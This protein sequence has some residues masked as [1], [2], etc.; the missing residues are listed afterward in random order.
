MT[1]Q[2]FDKWQL[3]RDTFNLMFQIWHLVRVAQ[4]DVYPPAG[5]FSFFVWYTT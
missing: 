2:T 1:G 3:E 5:H 4:N